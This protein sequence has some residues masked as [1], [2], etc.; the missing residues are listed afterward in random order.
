M[1]FGSLK[2]ILASL[3]CILNIVRVEF[4]IQTLLFYSNQVIWHLFCNLKYYIQVYP[5]KF[6]FVKIMR[7][8]HFKEYIRFFQKGLNPSKIQGRFKFEFV[9]KIVN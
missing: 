1:Y 3:V 2:E 8:G 9:P 6:T 4:Q 7:R 5:T